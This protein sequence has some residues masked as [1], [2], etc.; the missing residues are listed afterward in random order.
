MMV[1]NMKWHNRWEEEMLRMPKTATSKKKKNKLKNNE[2]T[3][4]TKN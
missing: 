4:K 3:K 2:Q 1:I